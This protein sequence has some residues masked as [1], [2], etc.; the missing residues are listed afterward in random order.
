MLKNNI[1]DRCDAFWQLDTSGFTD[2]A[3]TMFY[4]DEFEQ[5]MQINPL[6]YEIFSGVWNGL[7]NHV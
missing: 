6:I 1:R 2:M 7:Y 3:M 4:D 5:F